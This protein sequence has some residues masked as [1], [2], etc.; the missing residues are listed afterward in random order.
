MGPLVNEA[1]HALR[2]S[3]QA[4]PTRHRTSQ[5]TKTRL[6]V[7][8]FPFGRDAKDSRETVTAMA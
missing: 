8:R 7:A 4:T 2:Q 6:V 5:C 3:T 1:K